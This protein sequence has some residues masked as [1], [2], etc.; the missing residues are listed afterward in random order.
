MHESDTLSLSMSV[1]NEILLDEQLAQL[2]RSRNWSPRIISKLEAFI[3][4]ADD[5]AL[6]RVDPL[7]YAAEKGIS[8]NE[9]IDL[10]LQ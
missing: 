5:Y 6:F 7:Q 3:R 10:F 4:T 8:E 1:L 9:S 2:E